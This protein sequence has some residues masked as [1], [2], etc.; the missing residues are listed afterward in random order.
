MTNIQSL[1][2]GGVLLGLVA[3]SSACVVAGPRYHDGYYD[4][5]HHRYWHENAWHEC[6]ERDEHCH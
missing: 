5:E 2:R 4:H 6:G 1:V 3:L